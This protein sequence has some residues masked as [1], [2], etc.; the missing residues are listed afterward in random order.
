MPNYKVKLDVSKLDKSAFFKGAKGTYV[1]LVLWEN[2]DG[3]DQ[4]GNTHS[5]KQDLGKDR[6]DEKTPYVGNAKPIGGG[7]RDRTPQDGYR[8]KEPYAGKADPPSDNDDDI[9]F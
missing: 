3:E 8:S 1:D 7:G 4:Y 5:V 2:R 9:P 6:R